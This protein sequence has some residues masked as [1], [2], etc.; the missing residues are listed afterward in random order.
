[1]NSVD[2]LSLLL[3]VHNLKHALDQV[4]YCYFCFSYIWPCVYTH[5]HN[6]WW[7]RENFR[8]SFWTYKISSV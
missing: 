7:R 5:T 8:F 2:S 4:C 1:M 3:F 6:E